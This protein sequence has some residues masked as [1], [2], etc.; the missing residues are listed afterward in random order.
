M[1]NQNN[2]LIINQLDRQLE[3]LYPLQDL[4]QPTEGW[5]ALIRKTLKMSLRQLATRMS[6]TP[7]SLR[8]IEIREKKGTITLKTLKD[9]AKALDMKLVYGFVP[10]NQSLEQMVES[11]AAEMA[12]SIVIRTST[13][14]KLEDQENSKQR[15]EKA[16][17]ELTSEIKRQMPKILWD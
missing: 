12:R 5:V 15:L 3:K 6:I 11:K 4:A 8:D 9:A 1:N 2:T 13:T 17:A 10:Y 16:I 7:Q 14:M